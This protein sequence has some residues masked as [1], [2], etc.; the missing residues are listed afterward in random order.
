MYSTFDNR[1]YK[2]D[3]HLNINEIEIMLIDSC[4]IYRTP[5]LRASWKVY[6][7]Q[8]DTEKYG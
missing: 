4:P 3:E 1:F 7:E 6:L 8:Q 2:G 5:E